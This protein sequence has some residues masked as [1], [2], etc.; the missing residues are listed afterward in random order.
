MARNDIGQIS[1][2]AFEAPNIP[3][4]ADEVQEKLINPNIGKEG[5]SLNILQ[6]YFFNPGGDN[7]NYGIMVYYSLDEKK[8]TEVTHPFNASAADRP[9]GKK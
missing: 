6:Q 3:A 5:Y 8:Q 7:K 4:L 1:V 9:R 2:V